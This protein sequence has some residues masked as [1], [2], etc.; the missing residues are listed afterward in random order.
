MLYTHPP[1]V[2]Y[3]SQAYT[4]PLDPPYVPSLPS[5][6]AQRAAML[7]Q[8]DLPTAASESRTSSGKR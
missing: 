5:V 1:L 7:P 4:A 2:P 3:H 8:V 6:M